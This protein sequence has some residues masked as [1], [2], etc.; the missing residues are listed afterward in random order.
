[1]YIYVHWSNHT[2][3][4]PQP[5]HYSFHCRIPTPVSNLHPLLIKKTRNCS[6]HNFYIFGKNVRYTV[7]VNG[8]KESESNKLWFDNV[9]FDSGKNNGEAADSWPYGSQPIG[10]DIA[11]Q[12]EPDFY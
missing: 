12:H 11:S 5:L 4:Y 8:I 3:S 6:F 9:E 10:I 2:A 1:M 7:H